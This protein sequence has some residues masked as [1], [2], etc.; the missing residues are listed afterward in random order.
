MLLLLLLILAFPLRKRK[1]GCRKDPRA[2]GPFLLPRRP[3]GTSWSWR[4]CTLFS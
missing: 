2:A 4:L 1:S 3:R